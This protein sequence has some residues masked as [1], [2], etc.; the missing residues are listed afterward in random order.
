MTTDHDSN[1][2]P[3]QQEIAAQGSGNPAGADGGG[4][5]SVSVE[6]ATMHADD[7]VPAELV[8]EL[9]EKIKETA[10]RNRARLSGEVLE[11]DL[12]PVGASL[13]PAPPFPRSAL[14]PRLEGWAAAVQIMTDN[15]PFPLCALTL[16]GVVNHTLQSMA[17]V[18]AFSSP[19]PTSLAFLL[20]SNSGE[21]KSS[22]FRIAMAPVWE[23]E[24]RFTRAYE[25]KVAEL[26]ARNMAAEAA[27]LP[28]PILY[29]DEATP[30]AL[31]YYLRVGCGV[32]GYLTDEAGSLLAG[33]GMGT[34]TRLQM[35]TELAKLWDG[36]PI[37]FVRVKG[38]IGIIRNRRFSMMLMGQH[39]IL[40]PFIADPI[41]RTQ[42]LHSRI[43]MAYPDST[44]GL[45][46]AIPLGDEAG[47]RR[48]VGE[49]HRW[50]GSLLDCPLHIIDGTTN[51][52]RPPVME[53][54]AEAREML[55]GYGAEMQ[56]Y[57]LKIGRH[58]PLRDHGNKMP[59]ICT[60]IGANLKLLDEG[61]P[62]TLG[63]NHADVK[64]VLGAEHLARGIELARFFLKE[65]ERLTEP[66]PMSQELADARLLLSYMREA[67]KTAFTRSEIYK[68]SSKHR[69]R[70]KKVLDNV[71]AVLREYGW[72]KATELPKKPGAARAITLYQMTEEGLE[73]WRKEQ[74]V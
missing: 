51:E 70:D 42:G 41:C 57:M 13:P 9:A 19:V 58:N 64:W 49:Y 52:I 7:P 62:D 6:V 31:R 24:E 72:L 34:E 28:Q 69:L 74:G 56:R 22:V 10:A 44:L 66:A 23:A 61:S 18:R 37:K 17:D 48:V 36:T 53:L 32:S 33:H 4:Q 12:S 29:V 47:A 38:G 21:G 73:S 20:G 5:A 59:E 1:N 14:G 15:T 55:R 3:L 30:A 40:N 50:L 27:A 60:R 8:M 43:L 11:N 25:R 67:N 39:D 54:S 35:I 63:A 26:R 46:D 16:L 2:N 45:R 71:I 65:K 68:N